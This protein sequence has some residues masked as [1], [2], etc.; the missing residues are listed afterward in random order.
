M[1][2]HQR[3]SLT[4]LEMQV[5][6]DFKGDLSALTT[7]SFLLSDKSFIEHPMYWAQPPSFFIAPA[8]E[9]DPVRRSLALLKWF[10]VTRNGERKGFKKKPLNPFLGELFLGNFDQPDTGRTSVVAESV[11]HH[12]P[13]TAFRLENETHGI[14][15]QGY[16]RSKTSFSTTLRFE[17]VGHTMLHL[18]RYS[19]DYLI[20]SPK[21]FLSGF[22]PP[23]RQEFE[24][25][26]YIIG[27]N[28]ITI[29]LE[30]STKSWF[31]HGSYHSF[32]AR[33]YRSD[34]PSQ[35]IYT[36]KG[37]WKPE[38]YT[39]YDGATGAVLEVV[40]LEEESV[41]LARINVKTLAEQDPLETRRAWGPL[42]EAIRAGDFAKA[43][44][45]KG[46]I[47][48]AQRAARKRELE[49]GKVWQARYFQPGDAGLAEKLLARVGSKLR[50]DETKGA[51]RWRGEDG[52]NSRDRFSAAG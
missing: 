51:W 20:T 3:S 40:K 21:M 36:A 2:S 41:Q 24:G 26:S 30:F 9:S 52:V 18:S 22:L 44:A 4:K 28:S 48:E 12:P 35:A 14:R 32:T 17:H 43:T 38:N 42:A 1:S 11:S 15:L 27:S 39:V 37:T 23:W 13:I 19:E 8:L 50:E 29:E 6:R 45:E 49:E 33:A 10:I 5:M 16:S 25:R 7:P 46:K 34:A 47:E 31:G